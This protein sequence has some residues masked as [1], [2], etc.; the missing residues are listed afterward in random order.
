[1]TSAAAG[2]LVLALLNLVLALMEGRRRTAP[3]RERAAAEA[4]LQE[5]YAE[6]D[7]ALAEGDSGQVG[8]LFERE[9]REGLRVGVGLGDADAGRVQPHAPAGDQRDAR[10]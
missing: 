8:Q 4:D 3:Q 5:A 6:M 10:P 2:A 9:R 7:R 1:M